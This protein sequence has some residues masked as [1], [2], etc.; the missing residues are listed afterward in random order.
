M[1]PSAADK[2]TADEAK[3]KLEKP[4]ASCD[5]AVRLARELYGLECDPASVKQLDSYDD[6]NFFLRDGR[7]AEFVLKLHNGV[8]TN[9]LPLIQAQDTAMARVHAHAGCWAP[10]SIASR[11]GRAI[12]LVDTLPNAARAPPRSHAVRLLP[13]KPARLLADV[14][15]EPEL[16]AEV[17]RMLAGV[18]RALAD[19]DG[20]ACAACAARP[21][22]WDVRTVQS[23]VAPFLS[24]LADGADERA[25]VEGALARF[26]EL[27]APLDAELPRQL[28]HGDLN[29]QNILVSPAAEGA[30]RALGVIDFGDMAHTWR[31]CELGIALAYTLISCNYEQHVGTGVAE[32]AW[33]CCAALSRAYDAALPLS[34]AEWTALPALVGARIAAS[35]V[36][37]SYSAAL[38]PENAYLTLTLTPGWRALRAVAAVPADEMRRRLRGPGADADGSAP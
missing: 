10:V 34:E 12:E 25:L 30:A 38:Q 9:N 29:D 4:A 20:A 14:A 21:H 36:F 37:G 5:D 26:A 16:M 24:A 17:G 32:R 2:A 33:E 11:N 23:S 7:G 22:A 15:P 6:N 3:R 28:I 35:L 13:F 18:T 31:A 19:L 1:A 27:A 8:E